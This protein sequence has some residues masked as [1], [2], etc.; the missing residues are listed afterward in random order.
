MIVSLAEVNSYVEF[1]VNT[2]KTILYIYDKKENKIE[3]VF[4]DKW[5]SKSILCRVYDKGNDE[6]KLLNFKDIINADN[7]FVVV[8]DAISSTVR[9]PAFSQEEDKYGITSNYLNEFLGSSEFIAAYENNKFRGNEESILDLLKEY[10]PSYN[11]LLRNLFY[12]EDDSVLINFMNWLN[13]VSFS[14]KFQDVVWCFMGTNSEMQGQG[15]GKGVLIQIL[16]EMLSGLTVSVGMKTYESNFN[17]ELMNKKVCVFDEV[18]FK[19]LN[20]ATL[21]Y[22]TG[23]H[24]FRVESK[25]KDAITTPNVSSWLMFTNEYDLCEKVKFDDRRLFLIRPNPKNGSLRS[26]VIDPIYKGFDNFFEALRNEMADFIH[27]IALLD[28]KVL[29]PQQLQTKAHKDYYDG[30]MTVGVLDLSEIEDVLTNKK[31]AN[32]I[33][34]ILKANSLIEDEFLEKAIKKLLRERT[35]NFKAFYHFFKILQEEGMIPRKIKPM[36]AWERVKEHSKRGGFEVVIV[37]MA[38]TKKW[39]RYRD[40][41]VLTMLTIKQTPNKKR[42]FL[43]LK[44]LMRELFGKAVS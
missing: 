32:K 1:Y 8:V 43:E 44:K 24:V 10:C 16:E 12:N 26:L 18:E 14:D 5:P 30:L 4:S 7:D 25:G 36:F 22:I 13:V 37:D 29:T 35:L 2:N 23:K 39:E 19:E 15:A 28:G 20:W 6:V 34:E 9:P 31:M 3:H 33:V 40:K 27:L 11:K 21:K 17:S 38:K 41:S 42:K